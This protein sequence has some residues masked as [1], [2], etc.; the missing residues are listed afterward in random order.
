MNPGARRL[1]PFLAL[2]ATAFY[3]AYPE[4]FQEAYQ[5]TKEA[6]TEFLSPLGQR[7]RQGLS[8]FWTDITD[9]A[10]RFGLEPELVAA[11]I[12]QESKGNPG[13]KTW[14]PKAKPPQYSYGLMQILP[15]TAKDMGFYGSPEDLLDTAENLFWGTQY[16]KKQISRFGIPGG[17][18]AYNAGGP[19]KTNGDYIN[20]DYVNN[21]ISNYN[22]LKG[23]A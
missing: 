20:Q 22:A 13:I 5:E 23:I 11:V 14:E 3:L 2:L 1:L 18:A 19:Y 8:R 7:I 21:V 9:T 6:V 16:L 17:I 10:S 4:E 12:W 15:T